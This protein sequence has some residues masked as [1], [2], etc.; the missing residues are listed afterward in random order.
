MSEII[1]G[2]ERQWNKSEY[3]FKVIKK[4][5]NPLNKNFWAIQYKDDGRIQTQ[6]ESII[7]NNSSILK[8]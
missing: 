8:V 1:I 4:M 3:I 6:E 5:E 2:Q 7:L